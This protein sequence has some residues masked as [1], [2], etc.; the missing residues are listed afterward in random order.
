M[1][2]TD[3]GE[4]FQSQGIK[5][6]AT[7]ALFSFRSCALVEA[8]NCFEDPQEALWRGF[9]GPVTELLAK[10]QSCEGTILEADL[11]VSAPTP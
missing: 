4:K 9:M 11:L 3:D 2:P 6:T 1:R 10:N 7:S 8:S 5:D